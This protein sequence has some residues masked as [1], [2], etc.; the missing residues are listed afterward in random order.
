M[1]LR[2]RA[3]SAPPPLRTRKGYALMVVLLITLV[4]GAVALHAA[5]LGMNTALTQ[6]SSDRAAQMDDAALAGIEEARDRLNANLDSMP[7]TGYITIENGVAVSG[8]PGLRRWTYAGR[9]GNTNGQTA[10]GEYGVLGQLISQVRDVVGNT[11]IRRAEVYQESFARFASFT[12]L[13]RLADGRALF[14]ALGARVAGPVHS[15]DTI[16]VATQTPWPQATFMSDVTTAAIVEGKP[17]ADFVKAPPLEGVARIELPTTAEMN[18]LK[19]M[20]T[21][22]GYS[23][24]PTLV[25]GDSANATLRI[26]FLAIDTD[27]DG[28]TTGPQDGYFRVYRLDNVSR[29]PG[30]A[31]ASVPA[32]TGGAPIP[33]GD[34]IPRDS[35]MYSWNCGGTY[36]APVYGVNKEVT[37]DD[38]VFVNIPE[39]G[40]A[41]NTYADRMQYKRAAFDGPVARCFLGGD[42]R[43]N[44]GN[45]RNNDGAGRWLPRTAGSIPA[46]ISGRADAAY[47]WPLSPTLNPNFRG[48]IFVEGT[49]AVSGTVRGRVTLTARGNIVVAHNI[50]QRTNPGVTTGCKPDDDILGLYSNEYVLSADNLLIAPQWRRDDTPGG[51]AWLWPRKDFDPDT[52]RPDLIMHAITLSMKSDATENPDPPA[53][54]AAS[55]WNHR[56]VVRVIGGRIQNR[57]GS[58]GTFGPG[59]ELHGHLSDLSF[60]SCVLR[61]PPPFFPTTGRWMLAQYYEVNPLDFVPADWFTRP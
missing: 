43:L 54:L 8:S 23:F 15:N 39:F 53:G 46:S 14:W 3:Q 59:G 19:V 18:A 10:T 7:V 56:G 55:Q 28:L 6:G 49:V 13:S 29:G 45:F 58:R 16:R 26:E 52:R 44:G 41:T 12:N 37:R 2:R 47:L 50:E 51:T 33:A 22:A 61:F 60:N 21:A 30:Y 48:V 42:E 40:N 31:R 25:V 20:A 5:L 17:A 24:A 4:A 32:P 27:G 36:T 11:S 9:R 38:S 35:T 57:A 34:S 1:M